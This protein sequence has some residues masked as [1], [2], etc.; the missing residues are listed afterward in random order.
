LD[1]L[2]SV[3]TAA[4]DAAALRALWALVTELGFGPSLQAC[5]RDG[6]L[7][8]AEGEE[9]I[10]FSAGE[11]GVLCARCAAGQSPTRLPSEDYRDLLT[12]N[13]PTLELPSLDAPHAAAHRRLAARF[14]RHHLDAVSLSAL[15]FW[16]R[17]AWAQL[18][19]PA[20]IL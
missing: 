4:V 10:A 6:A 18:H 3:P 5:V 20:A 17:S 2:A 1:L 19:P 14:V 8:G 16:E 9:R 12:L 7:V 13:D 15:D 11:G